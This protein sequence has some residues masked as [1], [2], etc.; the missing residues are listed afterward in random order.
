MDVYHRTS[1]VGSAIKKEKNCSQDNTIDTPKGHTSNNWYGI[2][3]LRL[4][5]KPK[6]K[7]R[8]HKKNHPPYRDLKLSVLNN[9]GLTVNTILQILVSRWKN[10]LFWRIAHLKLVNTW[11]IPISM[12][13][14]I[15]LEKCIS[16]YIC[17]QRR[18]CSL[19]KKV[20][21]HTGCKF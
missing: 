12:Y 14:I 10:S 1:L 18:S 3:V 4:L 5:H 20:K 19:L 21:G 16:I 15:Q 9:W 8:T 2:V 7:C 17:F 11:F 13:Y 6:K